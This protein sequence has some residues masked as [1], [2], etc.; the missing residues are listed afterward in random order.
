L[1]N[2]KYTSKCDIWSIGMILY[3]VLYGYTAWSGARIE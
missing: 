2:S 1:A 3:N